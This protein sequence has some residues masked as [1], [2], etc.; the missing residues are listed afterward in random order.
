[1]T[2]DD[3]KAA[4]QGDERMAWARWLYYQ[5]IKAAGP[6]ALTQFNENDCENW[7]DCADAVLAELESVR[8]ADKAKIEQLILENQRLEL[9]VLELIESY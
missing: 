2:L 5:P 7:F 3:F 1:M 9:Q 4:S 6:E 8:E